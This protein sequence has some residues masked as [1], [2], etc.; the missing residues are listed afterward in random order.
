[1]I[2]SI[3]GVAPNANRCGEAAALRRRERPAPP[4]ALASS[5]AAAES[6]PCSAAPPAFP[7]KT[8][9]AALWRRERLLVLT[10]LR[11]RRDSAPL[12]AYLWFADSLGLACERPTRCGRSNNTGP[13]TAPLSGWCSRSRRA[14]WTRPTA[15]RPRSPPGWTAASCSRCAHSVV[16]PAGGGCGF[17]WRRLGPPFDFGFLGV[18][19]YD[20]ERA[21]DG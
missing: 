10:A 5:A 7:L 6:P 21:G 13:E 17:V 15:S 2:D 11:P 12:R 3:G 9:G 20:V 8:S 1:M 19:P 14:A 4:A 16:R 18:F